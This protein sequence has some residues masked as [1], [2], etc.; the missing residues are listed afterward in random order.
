MPYNKI[1]RSYKYSFSWSTRVTTLDALYSFTG[2]FT[3]QIFVFNNWKITLYLTP[4][5]LSERIY[6]AFCS[7][8]LFLYIPTYL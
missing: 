4:Q 7:K 8:L 2:D 5:T 3:P 1:Y 6:T